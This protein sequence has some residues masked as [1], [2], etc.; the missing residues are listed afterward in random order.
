ML[1]KP[2]AIHFQN[3]LKKGK[4]PNEWKHAIVTAIFKKG[5]KRKPNN[6]RPESITCIIS[7]IIESIIKRQNYGVYIENKNLFG[8]RSKEFGFLN[9]RSTVLQLLTVLEKWTKIIDEGGTIDC[10]YFNFKECI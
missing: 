10:V 4:L 6:Y 1:D 9:G 7:K 5:D 3:T 8:S 2:L